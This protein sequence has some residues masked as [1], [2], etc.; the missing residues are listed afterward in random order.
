MKSVKRLAALPL[1]LTLVLS[2]MAVG[3]AAER[4]PQFED[5]PAGAWYAE[6]VEYC[7]ENG[8]MSGTAANRFEPDGAM[9]RAM[10]AAAL[11]RQAGEPAAAGADGFADTGENAWYSSAVLWASREKIIN[12]YGNGL[13]GTE[14]PVTRE[15]IVT[16]LWRMAGSPAGETG[17]AFADQGDISPYAAAAAAWAKARGIVNGKEGNRFDPK[18]NATRAEVAAILANQ[19]KAAASDPTPAPVPAGEDLALIQGNVPGV[20]GPEDKPEPTPA[21]EGAHI[22]VAY[23]SATNNTEN[24]ANHIK[25]AF[26][27][28]ADLYEIVPETPYTADDLKYYTDCRADREQNDPTARPA[29]AGKVANME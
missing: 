1:A 15:Q 24:I 9:T 12:G 6:A 27:A 17:E 8:L 29:I 11:Y 7:R 21:P 3:C 26:G 18:G 28:E 4:Q 20:E 14:D 19:A 2:M 16:I 13:F 10:L 5:I 25:T 22:L 23:F